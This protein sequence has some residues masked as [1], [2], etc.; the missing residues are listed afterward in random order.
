[1]S[2]DWREPVRTPTEEVLAQF[3]RHRRLLSGVLAG[4]AVAT[5]LAVLRPARVISVPVVV[6]VSTLP[7]GTPLTGADLRVERLP[8]ADV[9]PGAIADPGE[10]T[11][12]RLDQGVPAGV[13]VTTEAIAGPTGLARGL[14]EDALT[15]SDP[16]AA[17]ALNVGETVDVV[18]AAPGGAGAA[19]VAAHV[20]L[21][22]LP[23]SSA[24]EGLVVVAVTPAEAL[25]L[26]AAAG[27]D[28]I[29]VLIEPPS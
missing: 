15:L 16:A 3:H 9:P 4:L 26:A 5:A 13:P 22:G 1:M 27:V 17:A 21:V 2:F 23:D 28:H 19:V 10:M 8:A 6:A 11:G 24:G 20:Q 25:D 14:V 12:R 18:A 7:V 29:S